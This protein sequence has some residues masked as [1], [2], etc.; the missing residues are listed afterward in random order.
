MGDHLIVYARVDK[1]TYITAAPLVPERDHVLPKV[2]FRTSEL[3]EALLL[4][5]RLNLVF[6]LYCYPQGSALQAFT[7]E[8]SS[9]RYR[10]TPLQ[11]EAFSF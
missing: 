6:V 9:S 4:K 7:A 3:L 5:V 10:N 11:A 1:P 8:P 2:K